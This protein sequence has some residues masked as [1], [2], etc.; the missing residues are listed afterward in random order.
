MLKFVSF[1]G[2]RR[3]SER[4]YVIP[5]KARNLCVSNHGCNLRF[6]TPLRSVQNDMAGC[7]APLRMTWLGAALRSE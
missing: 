6:F 7:C 2:P 4:C 5:S 1:R 3:H